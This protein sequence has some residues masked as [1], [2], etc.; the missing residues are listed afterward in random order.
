MLR[1]LHEQFDRLPL[2]LRLIV[3]FCV[4]AFTGYVML[5]LLTCI[6]GG[7]CCKSSSTGKGAYDAN[8]QAYALQYTALPADEKDELKKEKAAEAV[9][10]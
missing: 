8:L 10:V 6:A 1:D 5:K 3:A 4:G 9:V 2:F 7:R